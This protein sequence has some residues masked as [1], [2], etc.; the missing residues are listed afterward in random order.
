MLFEKENLFKVSFYYA[1][2]E[3][4]VSIQVGTNAT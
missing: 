1:P 3:S 4:K 2:H